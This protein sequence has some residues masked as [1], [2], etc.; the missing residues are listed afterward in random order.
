MG[1]SKDLKEV[2]KKDMIRLEH[3][4]KNI[5]EAMVI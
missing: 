5:K 2:D 3:Y 1:K 4:L